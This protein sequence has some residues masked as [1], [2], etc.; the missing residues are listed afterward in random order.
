MWRFTGTP[1]IG[2]LTGTRGTPCMKRLFF[3]FFGSSTRPLLPPPP[4]S[5]RSP[6]P[7]SSRPPSPNLSPCSK[8]V[9]GKCQPARGPE[10]VVK[11]FFPCPRKNC[12][13]FLRRRVGTGYASADLWPRQGSRLMD[14][15]RPFGLPWPRGLDSLKT[16]SLSLPSPGRHRS[17]LFS[18]FPTRSA[19]KPFCTGSQVFCPIPPGYHAPPGRKVGFKTCG[20][21]GGNIAK[22]GAIELFRRPAG[23]WVPPGRITH[24]FGDWP[25]SR[26]WPDRISG[27]HGS[28]PF[29][30]GTPKHFWTS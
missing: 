13:R 12:G 25:P 1:P 21:N 4:P 2:T 27:D 10:G 22:H 6:W 16:A 29:K 23:R 7:T 18:I 15:N 30:A 28:G 11:H 20:T 19:G 24:R 9:H 3:M 5:A 17:K 26:S 8:A 14:S